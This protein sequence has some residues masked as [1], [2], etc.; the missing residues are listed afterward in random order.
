MNRHFSYCPMFEAFLARCSRLRTHVRRANREVAAFH[1]PAR[2]MG[3]LRCEAGHDLRGLTIFGRPVYTH[4]GS[5]GIFAEKGCSLYA[6]P[7]RL[8]WRSEA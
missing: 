3:L 8:E 4:D 1:V 6:L 5:G 7:V 2:T